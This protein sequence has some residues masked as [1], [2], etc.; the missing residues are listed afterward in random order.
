M[1]VRRKTLKKSLEGTLLNDVIYVWHQISVTI[2]DG[3]GILI[4]VLPHLLF[5]RN[6]HILP[7]GKKFSFFWNL[8]ISNSNTFHEIWW[9]C[10]SIIRNIIYK[11]MAAGWGSI[12]MVLYSHVYAFIPRGPYECRGLMNAEAQNLP[13]E[14][15]GPMIYSF[16][17]L[18]MSY[19][20]FMEY[21]FWSSFLCY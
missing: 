1:V 15:N 18:F 12:A 3:G 13:S 9:W 21:G 4:Q 10:Y 5:L 17:I 11:N 7:L 19:V 16:I 2:H 14:L 20:D 8:N 6:M